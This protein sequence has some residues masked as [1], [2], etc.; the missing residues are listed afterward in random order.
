MHVAAE[1]GVAAHWRYKESVAGGEDCVPFFGG[2][3]FT[4]LRGVGLFASS[5]GGYF[6]GM[7]GGPACTGRETAGVVLWVPVNVARGWCSLWA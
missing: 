4:F 6:E 2:G 1:Y 7:G 5:S 3:L